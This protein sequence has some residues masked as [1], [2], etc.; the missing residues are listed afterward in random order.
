MVSVKYNETPVLT[1]LATNQIPKKIR[2][3]RQLFALSSKN[4]IKKGIFHKVVKTL[5]EVLIC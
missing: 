1:T 4:I 3:A 2:R 5:K